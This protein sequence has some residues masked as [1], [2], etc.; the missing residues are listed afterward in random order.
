MWSEESFWDLNSLCRSHS[1]RL[2]MEIWCGV[3][4]SRKS[5]SMTSIVSMQLRT[6]LHQALEFWMVIWCGVDMF[7]VTLW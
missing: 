6:T 3:D 1:I 7:L 4:M 2:W 5:L